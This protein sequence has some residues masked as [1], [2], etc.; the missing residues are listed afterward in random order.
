[1][2]LMEDRSASDRN[3]ALKRMHDETRRGKWGSWCN[4]KKVSA[5]S[6]WLLVP[7]FLSLT[8]HLV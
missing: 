4:V 2:E 5:A 6:L 1:M 8:V 3:I 7:I